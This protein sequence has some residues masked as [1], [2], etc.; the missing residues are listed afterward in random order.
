MQPIHP[1]KGHCAPGV[2]FIQNI[3]L[4]SLDLNQSRTF[5][6]RICRM[7]YLLTCC[8]FFFLFAGASRA[9]SGTDSLLTELNNLLRESSAFDAAKINRIAEMRKA[10]LPGGGQNPDQQYSQAFRLYDEYRLFNY[11]SAFSYARKLQELA[12]AAGNPSRI[13]DA[14]LKMGFTLLSAGLFKEALDTLH[15][16]HIARENRDTR[17]EYYF[18]MGRFYYDL[19]DFDND[20]NY[21]P[22]YIRKGNAYIDSALELSAPGS[23][24]FLYYKGLRELK[25]ANT[26]SAL[27]YFIQTMNLP[28]LTLHQL[29]VA[30]STLS[31]IYIQTGQTGRA[32]DLLIQAAI[33]DIRSSTKETAAIFNLAGLLFKKGDVKNASLYIEQALDDAMYYGARQRK[34]QVS[35][36]MPLI[37]GEKLNRVETQ[38]TILIIYSAIATLLLLTVIVLAIVIWKQVRK[39]KAA[40]KTITAAN[41]LQQEI[42]YKLQEANK[43]KEEYIGF[44]FNANSEFFSRIERFKK[45]VEQKISDRKIDEIRFLVNNINIK[46]EKNELISNFDRAFLKLFPNF[47]VAYNQLFRE[48]DQVKLKEEELL[49]TDM[50]I[51]ALIR[52]CI[53]DNE[54]IARILE[55]SVNT[56]YTYKTRIKNKSIVPNEEFEERIMEIKTV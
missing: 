38:K 48:E 27:S 17:A 4:L 23:F 29:A 47:V 45:L 6:Q 28:D 5:N 15:T 14:R 40:R 32:I 49:N 20:R 31:D 9:N 46:K 2:E 7:R 26:E 39:L 36:I 37:E 56:I 53:H 24:S 19:A 16:I 18:L 33:A 52:M 25:E 21:T 1:L 13:T 8:L 55:Y 42:N 41:I 35:S 10:F 34:I 51:F 11:D 3:R 43:I 12:A 54:R 44:F 50:R 22:D 30:A